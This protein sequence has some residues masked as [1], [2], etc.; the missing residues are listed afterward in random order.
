MF[1]FPATY[2]YEET[3]RRDVTVHD[4]YGDCDLTPPKGKRFVAF[5]PPK[6]GEVFLVSYPPSTWF[7]TA[8]CDHP[9]NRP[10]LLL[11]DAPKRR[12]LKVPLDCD[13][14]EI[15]VPWASCPFRVCV[16]Q[17]IGGIVFEEDPE[18]RSEGGAA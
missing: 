11:G 7:D 12:Y 10:R 1:S 6:R 17:V 4:V 13:S 8:L 5:R 18:G 15:N 16:S 3:V 14:F 9:E 2:T